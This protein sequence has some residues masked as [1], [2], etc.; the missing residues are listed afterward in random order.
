MQGSQSGQFSARFV[1][2]RQVEEQPAPDKRMRLRYSGTCRLCGS[3][4]PAKVEAVYERT[5]NTVRCLE[6]LAA[7]ETGAETA[8][9]VAAG[10]AA[11]TA[12]ASA[13]REHLRR[14]TNRAERIRAG[15]PKVGGLILALS[16]DPQTTEAWAQGAVG[17]ERLG[18]RLDALASPSLA[19][20]HDRRIPGTK[21]NIDH[22]VVTAA[23]VWVIDAKRYKGRPELKAE[24]G[25]LRPR[26]ERLLVDKR[27]RT[28]LVDGV[29]RQVALVRHSLVADLPVTGAL[30]FVDADWPLVGG[31]FVIRGVEVL[32]P[33]RL[34]KRLTALGEPTLG[35]PSTVRLLASRFPAA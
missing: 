33:K 32:W 28:T 35:V 26:V 34:A 13:R 16:H 20:L 7:P 14:K 27:D 5:T 25:F 4:L 24:G 11:G 17:E 2:V 21:A 3:E 10:S 1:M 12:G 29:L 31:S 15:H 9:T 19:V 6:C 22:V 23:G 8:D 30:C 18:A